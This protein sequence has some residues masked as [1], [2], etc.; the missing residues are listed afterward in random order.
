VKGISTI[1]AKAETI[2]T[3][4]TFRRPF[5]M[6]RCLVPADGFYEWLRVDEK[7]KQPYAF[8]M[9]DDAPFA[10]AGVWD[11]WKAWDGSWLQSYSIITTFANEL[12]A[13]VH[14]RMPVILHPKDYDRWLERES[15]RA[16]VDLLRPFEAEAMAAA[17]CNPK[18]GNAKNNGP[19]MLT[20]A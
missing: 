13:R 7:T 10:F 16:P 18:V 6:R 8:R 17:P 20:S 5:K 19:E 4:P 14:S 1:N 3:S 12:A 9:K 2:E 11:A 15:E